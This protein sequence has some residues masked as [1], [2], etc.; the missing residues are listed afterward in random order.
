MWS[1]WRSW[2]KFKAFCEQSCFLV[3]KVFVGHVF[4]EFF[5]MC[6]KFV[7]VLIFIGFGFSWSLLTYRLG[8]RGFGAGRVSKTHI[9]INCNS[10]SFIFTFGKSKYRSWKFTD[11]FFQI[12][13]FGCL[14][15]VGSGSFGSVGS[16]LGSVGGWTDPFSACSRLDGSGI[17][18]VSCFCMVSMAWLSALTFLSCCSI[19]SLRRFC[20]AC[21]QIVLRAALKVWSGLK[22]GLGRYWRPTGQEPL[23]TCSFRTQSDFFVLARLVL[24]WAILFRSVLKPSSVRGRLGAGWEDGISS[25]ELEL[26]LLAGDLTGEIAGVWLSLMSA[27]MAATWLSFKLA[28]EFLKE[29]FVCKFAR[30]V[31]G[32][33]S[34]FLRQLL[35]FCAQVAVSRLWPESRRGALFYSPGRTR[36]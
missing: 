36:N 23:L 26:A 32:T 33:K 4:N 3:S 10:F 31:S 21:W 15:L 9:W 19:M 11:P 27:S 6:P 20:S 12:W 25:S 35:K 2:D 14:V 18:V 28:M 13:Y 17:M 22:C 1:R 29:L 16:A 30:P 8:S 24:E 34:R 5:I 7:F